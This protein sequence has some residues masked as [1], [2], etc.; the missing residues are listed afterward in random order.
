ML[1]Q[2]LWNHVII[3]YTALLHCQYDR[4][5]FNHEGMVGI[6]YTFTFMDLSHFI[7]CQFHLQNASAA[8]AASCNGNSGALPFLKLCSLVK[9]LSR[10]RFD[11]SIV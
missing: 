11:C 5:M 9:Q 7:I 3:I 2:A 4:D 1:I 10:L 6:D 8:D